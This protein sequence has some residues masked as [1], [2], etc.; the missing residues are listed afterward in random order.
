MLSSYY[1]AEKLKNRRRMAGKLMIA[2]P[3]V[4]TLFSAFLARDYFLVDNYNWWYI[5]AYPAVAALACAQISET[6]KRLGDWNI[7]TLPTD[8]KKIWDAKIL[9]GVRMSAAGTLL[10]CVLT[11][12][13]SAGMQHG[14]QIEFEMELGIGQQ[15]GAWAILFVAFLWQIPFCM[16]LGQ[17]M[18]TAFMLIIHMFIYAAASLSLSLTPYFLLLPGAVP[19][20]MMCIVI[21]ILPNGLPAREGMRTFAPALLDKK[22]LPMGILGAIAW[23]FF[24]WGISRR[25]YERQ[26]AG[27]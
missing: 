5:A 18:G 2:M 27:R 10:M 4:L 19:A 22:M 3:V 9:W 14:L 11:M 23:F 8:L 7:L 16:L 24:L 17:L 6:D 25:L 12:L 20:R 26:V 1:Q 21:H 13:L 15:I